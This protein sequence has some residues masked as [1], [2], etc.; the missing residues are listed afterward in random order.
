MAGV[1]KEDV[2]EYIKAWLLFD[3]VLAVFLWFHLGPEGMAEMTCKV[4]DF[5]ECA[6]LE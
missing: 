2:V 3:L 6:K 5:E 1:T 4:I